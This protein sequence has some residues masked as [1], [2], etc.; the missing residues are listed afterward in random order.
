MGYG[1]RVQGNDLECPFH[2][3]QYNAHGAVTQIPYARTI[4]PQAKRDDCVRSWRVTEANGF[5]YVWYHP[6]NAPPKFAVDVLPEV[7]SPDWTPYKRFEW[8]VFNS[9]SNMHDNGLDMAHFM[10]VHRVAAFP[11]SEI[12][13]DGYRMSA[14]SRAKMGT[15]RGEVDGAIVSR[16][17]SPG[18]GSVR[19]QGICET[20]LVS[21]ITPVK[22]D[23]LHVRFAFTQPKAEAEGPMAGLARALV[24]DICKQLDQDKTIWDRQRDEPEPLMCDGDGPVPLARERFAMFLSDA[25]FEAGQGKTRTFSTRPKI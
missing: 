20:M 19:F 22:A 9:I 18:Q 21:A 25:A 6:E 8:R 4:P 5:V 14:V 17:S 10:Y 7:G 3:W 12:T 15:P 11:Q 24:R 16:N 13:I 1:G 2:A 23:E